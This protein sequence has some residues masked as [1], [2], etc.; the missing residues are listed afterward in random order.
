MGKKPSNTLPH[1]TIVSARLPD[2]GTLWAHDKHGLVLL[3][4]IRRLA[5]TYH[6]EILYRFHVYRLN[7]AF[8]TEGIFSVSDWDTQFT[9]V[10]DATH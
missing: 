7:D 9:L 2:L 5:G 3:T 1:S 4:N 8:H 6:G 10:S